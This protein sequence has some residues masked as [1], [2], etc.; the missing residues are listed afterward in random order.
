MF[1][2]VSTWMGDW[3]RTVVVSVWLQLTCGSWIELTLLRVEKNEWIETY[4]QRYIHTH[5][6]IESQPFLRNGWL[7]IEHNQMMEK[8]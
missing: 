5:R 1:Y 7:K 3:L 6:V 4:I 8:L 2:C